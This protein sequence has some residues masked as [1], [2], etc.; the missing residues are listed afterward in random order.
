MKIIK[1]FK[2]LLKTYAFNIFALS[3]ICDIWFLFGNMIFFNGKFIDPDI[4]SV[5][6]RFFVVP[7]YYLLKI[8]IAL[9]IYL[10]EQKYLKPISNKFIT[11]NKFYFLITMLSFLIQAIYMICLFSFYLFIFVYAFAIALF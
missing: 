8:L 11:E 7:P 5:I 6:Y 9:I 4:D 2:S 3:I 1:I 10:I